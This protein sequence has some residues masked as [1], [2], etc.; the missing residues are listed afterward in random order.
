MV[1]TIGGK[2]FDVDENFYIIPV[3]VKG[4]SISSKYFNVYG[5]FAL[6]L[7]AKKD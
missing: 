4:S 1:K 2:D 6:I 7:V 5:T 3:D